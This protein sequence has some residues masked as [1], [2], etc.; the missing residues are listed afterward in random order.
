MS[1]QPELNCIHSFPAIISA[2]AR[3]LV[4]G[5]I[6]S[7]ASLSKQQYYG[8]QRNAFWPIMGSLFG[9]QPTLDYATRKTILMQHHI[10]VW[11]VLKSCQRKGSLDQNID[12]ESIYMNDFIGLFKQHSTIKQ[13]FFNG[14]AAETVYIRHVLPLVIKDCDY[15][16]YQRLP[17]TS[18]AHAALNLQQ[19]IAAWQV[20]K[21]GC[22]KV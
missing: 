6:P 17:S 7:I 14:A 1:S 22:D 4:L 11:D 15:L 19:K 12:M 16:R 2:Q 5:S 9:A 18:P 21:L 13:V 20:I 8:H 3:V 10:A